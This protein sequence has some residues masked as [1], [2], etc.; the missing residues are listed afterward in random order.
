MK[1]QRSYP[2]SAITIETDQVLRYLAYRKEEKIP[3]WINETIE[4]QKAFARPLIKPWG[5]Y[6]LFDNISFKEHEVLGGAQKLAFGICSIGQELEEAAGRCFRKKEYL[7]G[8][9]LDAIGTVAAENLAELVRQEIKGKASNF[10]L[11]I[12]KRFSPGY[13][14]WLLDGQ[15]LIFRHF[16]DEPLRVTT[17]GSFMMTPRK[18]LSFAYKLGIQEFADNETGNCRHCT[19]HT[20][21][22]YRK[23]DRDNTCHN[24]AC[25]S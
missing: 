9:L 22:A 17:N 12:S 23:D 15:R 25:P 13:N 21:C 6:S 8:M 24:A 18:S 7:E 2:A 5:I 3:L 16:S 10:G 1:S 14:N 20:R 4:Q 19:L 11:R